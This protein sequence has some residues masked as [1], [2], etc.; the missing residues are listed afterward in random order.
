[1]QESYKTTNFALKMILQDN[2]LIF[3]AIN[4]L[5]VLI[6][7][8]MG[9]TLGV[10]VMSYVRV[11]KGVF[12]AI[13]LVNI[14]YKNGVSTHL[15]INKNN[16]Y[17]TIVFIFLL[18]FLALDYESSIYRSITFIYPFLYIIYTINYLLRYGALNLLIVLSYICLAVYL[19]VPL[20][21]LFFGGDLSDNGTIYG[22]TEG[23]FF[24]SNHY[25]WGSVMVI[26]SGLTV[27]RFF[28]INKIIKLFLYA[29]LPYV[30][31]LLLISANRAGMLALFL[32]FLSFIIKDRFAT[33]GQK[34]LLVILPILMLLYISLQENSVIDFL[35]NKNEIQLETGEEGRFLT[36]SIMFR[37]FTENPVKLFTGVGMF[38]YEVLKVN[39]GVLSTYHNS[40]WDIFFGSGIII[41]IFF[42]SFMI[43]RPIITFF[44]T[45]Y[46]Y[47]LLIIPLMIIPFFEGNL[48]AGQFLFFPWF[49][50]MILLNAKEFYIKR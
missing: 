9:T 25:G 41:F 48:T 32:A 33:I 18:S 19:I 12:L 37:Y 3:F 21:Y 47:S 15:I 39:G 36:T 10:G 11:F 23:E 46:N 43:F 4:C 45:T 26:L 22:Y 34:L 28:P 2:V 24:V 5:L 14:L 40:Y 7:Y 6:G 29:F 31:Y 42:L 20:S 35:K 17:V 8:A 30:F 49:A 38:N 16:L 1:M 50:Y 27:I 44:K 13:S